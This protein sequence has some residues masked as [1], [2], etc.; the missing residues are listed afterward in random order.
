MASLELLSFLA[1]G[2]RQRNQAM[3]VVSVRPDDLEGRSGVLTLLADLGRDSATDRI[4]LAPLSGEG[5]REL[6]TAILGDPPD[7]SFVERVHARS[8][9]NPLFVEELLA[10]PLDPP[11]ESAVPPKLRDLVAVRLARVPDDAWPCCA[12]RRRPVG[13]STTASS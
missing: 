11:P 13:R 10:A 9:G 1:H 3:V 7:E 4:E 2:L 8:D 12:S 5:T 6:M